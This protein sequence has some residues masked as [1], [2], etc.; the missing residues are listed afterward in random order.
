LD[1]LLSDVLRLGLEIFLL[2]FDFLLSGNHRRI[3]VVGGNVF[4]FRAR[5]DLHRDILREILEFIASGDKVGF[6]VDFY[7]DTDL[8][9]S[10]NV[11]EDTAFGGDAALLLV[12]RGH[13]LDAQPLLRLL[14]IT[15]VQAES[16]LAIHHTG[17]GHLSE[18]LDGSRGDGNHLN[19]SVVLRLFFL[20]L[21]WLRRFSLDGSRLGNL[22]R[23]VRFLLLDTFTQVKSFEA[24][25]GDLLAQ[26]RGGFF[27]QFFNRLGR[28][29]DVILRQERLFVDHFVDAALDNLLSDVLRL[30]LEIFLLHFDFLLSGNHRR[31]AVVGGNVFNFRARGDLHR[32]IL[33]EILEF[34][35][36][37][38][39]VGFAVDFYQDT[40][41][42][43]SVNVRE[44]TAFGGDAALLLVRR[45]HAL[46]AQPLLRF[47]DVTVVFNQSF[48]AIHHTCTGHL[49]ELF[50]RSRGDGGTISSRSSSWCSR[51]GNWSGSSGGWCGFLCSSWGGGRRFLSRCGRRR[52]ARR[53]RSRLLCLREVV[54]R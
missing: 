41:L 13:A 25:D 39:K 47:L 29:L 31:I 24:T 44:D 17:T 12:R 14:N 3:A 11:R 30:G 26:F 45:G 43:T 50:N 48:L 54:R 53:C 34:I 16:F 6:A 42:R 7:Q 1:N 37:G 35:A 18:L 27:D 36:S 38:D 8:R 9:T 46:D 5:G 28:V 52:H 4:N 33:R 51:F 32:D 2:H 21:S 40:D 22:S 23:E 15:T 10:V 19:R 49:S 20:R